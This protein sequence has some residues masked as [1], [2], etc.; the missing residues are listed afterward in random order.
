MEDVELVVY[1]VFGIKKIW[2]E[3]KNS[4]SNLYMHY[5]SSEFT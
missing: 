4:L 3:E 2:F 5:A 1:D